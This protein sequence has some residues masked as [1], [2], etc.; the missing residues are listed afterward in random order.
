MK[1]KK[2]RSFCESTLIMVSPCAKTLQ[3]PTTV[4][5]GLS[6][7]SSSFVSEGGGDSHP[8]GIA[9]F[10]LPQIPTDDD[11]CT[12]SWSPNHL[13]ELLDNDTARVLNKV[14]RISTVSDLSSELREYE[15]FDGIDWGERHHLRKMQDLRALMR[16]LFSSLDEAQGIQQEMVMKKKS[17]RNGLFRLAYDLVHHRIF[18]AVTMVLIVYALFGPDLAALHGHVAQHNL[19]LAIVNTLVM[20]SFALEGALMS[21]VVEGYLCSGRFWVDAFAT[22]SMIGDTWI[23][24]ELVD[25]DVAAAG[26][27]SRLVRLMRMTRGSRI[28]RLLRLARTMQVVRL[29]PR[30]QKIIG[31]STQDLALLVFH[32]RMFHCFLYLDTSGNGILD[33]DAT[34]Y[35]DMA[36]R[37]EFPPP[38]GVTDPESN[39]TTFGART[40]RWYAEFS[41]STFLYEICF[42]FKRRSTVMDFSTEQSE[43]SFKQVM[44]ELL[45]R[46]VGKRALNRCLEDIRS[47]KECCE[48]LDKIIQRLMLKVIMAVI[49]LIVIMSLLETSPIDLSGLQSLVQL[50]EMLIVMP[51]VFSST[52]MCSF[53][54]RLASENTRLMLLVLNHTLYWDASVCSCCAQASGAPFTAGN[55]WIADPWRSATDAMKQQNLEFHEYATWCYPNADCDGKILSLALLDAQDSVRDSAASSLLY[56]VTAV[57]M[58]MGFVMLFSHDL[59]RL[60]NNHLLH[61]LWDILDDMCAT[62]C[63]EVVSEPP[64]A[65]APGPED[66]L[67][68]KRLCEACRD[69]IPV[70]EELTQLKKA[71]E[72]LRSAMRSWCK[73]VPGILFQQLY[74]SGVEA[75]IGMARNEVTVLFV[76][77]CDFQD[78]C[79]GMPPQEVLSYL[80]LVL[81]KI[82]E[83]VEDWKGTLLEFIGDEVLAVWNAPQPLRNHAL[84]ALLA[85][86]EMQERMK[87]IRPY[88]VKLHIGVHKASVLAGNIGSR[89]RIKYGVLGDGVNT[90]ARLKSLNTRFGT[91]ILASGSALEACMEQ[92]FVTRPIGNLVLKGR[93]QPMMTYEVL[94]RC[95]LASER[96]VFGA[97]KHR[98]AFD[99]MG[100]RCFKEAKI[101][102]SE[103]QSLLESKEVQ[104][105][106]TDLDEYA[107]LTDR[108]S[109][110]LA[111]LCDEYIRNPQIGRAHV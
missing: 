1:G 68:R 70:A 93:T 51:G 46:P 25:T 41:W 4:E 17:R 54:E 14:R 66:L 21:W 20:L 95:E 58:L 53:V 28:M 38:D 91:A 13:N 44:R 6:A 24:H 50:S 32:K 86:V 82:C 33:E 67:R 59:H 35:L 26:K 49:I 9:S 79:R 56:T 97:A 31:N 5:V 84:K 19:P 61:P 108:P 106:L 30:L 64:N 88:D 27:G 83:I 34:Q 45:P 89:T 71:F 76:D 42:C 105:L 15:Q 2:S 94:G 104:N 78:Q 36:I 63:L 12:D 62:K 22:A 43:G 74:E 80:G 75:A 99:L 85:A 100:V 60:A 57:I 90:C 73:Y 72:R 101:L 107:V 102:F 8:L 92:R 47:M 39:D 110:H 77:V 11:H 48:A 103:V 111:A 3:P 23:M 7:Q 16:R 109:R 37:M 96:L 10:L 65:N 69:S 87:E 40:S 55:L 29:V 81:E 98:K 18:S 52:E